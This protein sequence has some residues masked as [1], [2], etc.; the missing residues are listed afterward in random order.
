MRRSTRIS[1]FVNFDQSQKFHIQISIVALILATLH[2]IGHLGG[3]FVWGSRTENELNVAAVLG[4][5]L[6]PRPYRNYLASLPGWSGIVTLTLFYVLSL[7]S[8]PQVRKWKY[9]AFQLGHLLMYPIIAL[10]CAHGTLALLQWPMLGYF[11]ALP[12]LLVLIERVTRVMMGFHGIPAT[13]TVLDNQTLEIKTMIPSERLWTYQAG[14]YI[15]L[16]VPKISFFQW[17]PFTVSACVDREM[18]LH[19]KVDGSW[20]KKLRVLGGNNGS[21]QIRI[22]VNGPF[23]APAQRFYQFDHTVIVGAGIGVT[24][25]SGILMDLQAK[26]DR[27][28]GCPDTVESLKT[29]PGEKRLSTAPPQDECTAPAKSLSSD[30]STAQGFVVNDSQP[31]PS[32]KRQ[33]SSTKHH[34]HEPYRRVDFHWMVRDRNHLFW[35]SDLLN[36]VSRSQ[37]WHQENDPDCHLEINIKTH[38][39]QKRKNIATH[40]YRW[41]LEM[42]RTEDHPESPLTGLVNSTHFGRPDFEQI[43]DTHYEDMRELRM[44]RKEETPEVFDER[45]KVGVFYCGT[46]VIGAILADRCSMLSARGRTDGSKIEYHFMM[47]VFG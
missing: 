29:G 44:K 33:N 30:R 18:R 17:H 3:S 14:Q 7:L 19:I 36:T 42:H 10:W 35:F 22:G 27:L 15:F 20:T 16:Q 1:R 40:V 38:V 9:E 12:T 32:A 26:D 41:L 25:F 23:G 39:T 34:V 46:P 24:P 13:L 5:D 31:T 43:L 6:V 8:L 45:L 47:E 11:L 2:A 37:I 21:R 4:P 28:H